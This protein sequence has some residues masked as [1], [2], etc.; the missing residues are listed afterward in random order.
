MPRRTYQV[1][2]IMF[3]F[4]MLFAAATH[5]QDTTA[6]AN[7][8]APAY[9]YPDSVAGMQ[10]QFDE[11]IRLI[12]SPDQK[13]FL[14]A[15]DA[16]EIAEPRDWLTAHFPAYAVEQLQADY[17]KA[18]AGYRSHV[19]WVMGN[20]AKDRSFRVRAEVSKL[21]TPLVASGFEAAFTETGRRSESGELPNHA[22][23]L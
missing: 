6:P 11:L 22:H 17:E 13:P 2:A 5:A 21:P 20:F 7:G 4:L 10:S 19:W 9:V 14:D 1:C 3:L 16:L 18:F 8:S 15:L 23:G 12:R